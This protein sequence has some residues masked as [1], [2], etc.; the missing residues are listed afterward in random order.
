MTSLR[1]RDAALFLALAG[2]VAFFALVEPAFLGP[3]NLS[4]LMI[5]LSITAC[6]ALGMLLVILPG[7]IDLAAG[8]GVGLTGGA[9]A[10]L[11]FHHGWPAPFAM[12]AGALLTILLWTGMGLLIVRQKM[13]AF[14]VTLGG[15]LAFKGVFWLVIQ[16]A[17]V[18]V[19]PGGGRNLL[20]A[21]TTVF[22]PAWL[23]FPLAALAFAAAV[24]I[25]RRFRARRLALRLAVD[26]GEMFFLKLFVAAQALFILVW[27]P[28]QYRG[29]PLSFVL[30]ALLALAVHLLIRH[31]VLGRHLVAIG[32]NEEAARVAGI[33]VAATVITAFA[34]MGGVVALTGFLQTAYAGASTT[35]V[36][37][38]MELD[39]IAACVI[40]GASL[41]GGRG[42]VLG[43]LMGALIMATLLN[44]MTLLAVSPETKFIARGFILT[45][46]VWL[47]LTLSR[48][49]Q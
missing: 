18:P 34:L 29:L 44:G 35:T 14:I 43:V 38:L 19:A 16:N 30:L 36:G 21:L 10:V 5:E 9:A 8:S 49:M 48:R 45:L 41:K 2:I 39:A 11:I 33:P 42:S 32:G 15:L 6:L 40:G 26:P 24:V 13:P 1:T 28:C 23:A 22:L 12:A 31:T 20:S 47:D 17:T 27:I 37:E 4:Q 25:L 46:A 3:R 7:H